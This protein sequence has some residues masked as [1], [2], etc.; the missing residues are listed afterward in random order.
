MKNNNNYNGNA[1]VKKIGVSQKFTK[2]QIKEYVKCANDILYFVKTYCKI[3]TLDHGMRL[4]TPYTYQE[5]MIK[6]FDERRFVVNL[7]PRQMGKTTIVAAY[8]LHYA[9]FNSDK[10]I[11]ILANKASTSREILSRIKRM[12]ENLPLWMQPGVKEWNKGMI[13]LGNESW[14]MAAA[15][16]SDSIRGFAFN[17]IY[18][19]EFAHVDQQMEFWESTY[20]VISSGDTSKVIITSTPK[21]LELF[22]KIYSE[23]EKGENDFYPIK[24]HWNEHPKRDE[25]WKKT[26]ISNIGVEQFRQEYDCE[27]LGSSGSLISGAVLQTMTHKE[28]IHRGNDL[29]NIFEM[30]V[31]DH[32]YVLMADV[33]RGKGLDYSAFSVIDISEMPYKQVAIFRDNLIS[34][35]EYAE[36]IDRVGKQ[37][38]EASVLIEINDIGAQVSDLLF[39]DYDYENIIYTE[40]AGRL[41]KRVSNRLGK[42]VDRGLRTTISTKN[43]GCSVIKLLIEQN[44][45][46]INDKSTIEEL[47]TFTR[48]NKSYEA[49]SG[50]NDDMVMGLVIFGWLTSQS[51]FQELTDINTLSALRERTQEELESQMLPL[52][53]MNDGVEDYSQNIVVVGDHNMGKWLD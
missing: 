22:H 32:V 7:L 6:A 37:Y 49:E 17:I 47:K 48:K 15:T 53:F 8:L 43:T 20:P 4:F 26:T 19:D 28:P 3:V 39:F 34:P 9:I 51:Y 29:F 21:G 33:S 2:E 12:Y 52:G 40:T 27:F 31:R 11:G 30:P 13:S 44:Q 5:R 35:V 1:L 41:G 10:S 24:V 46:L 42:S 38:N 45:L 18:L 14:I 25:K 16:S 36:I 50:K 23:A